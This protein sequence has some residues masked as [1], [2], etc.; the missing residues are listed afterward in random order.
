MAL[1]TTAAM[2]TTY[3]IKVR[4]MKQLHRSLDTC[5]DSALNYKNSV[6][7]KTSKSIG[8]C[9]SRHI[10][11]AASIMKILNGSVSEKDSN[12][13]TTIVEFSIKVRSDRLLILMT[14]GH[15]QT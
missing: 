4:M 13:S 11:A 12:K 8:K 3:L 10:T 15:S 1:I 2:P 5:Q 14:F 9:I 7:R 6:I